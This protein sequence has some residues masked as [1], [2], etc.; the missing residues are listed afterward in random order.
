MSIQ[1]LLVGGG[2]PGNVF[3]VEYLVVGGGGP[4]A[5]ERA[6]LDADGDVRQIVISHVFQDAGFHFVAGLAQLARLLIDLFQLVVQLHPALNAL[7]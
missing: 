6:V 7:F 5:L 2:A 4:V 1:Q 3:T